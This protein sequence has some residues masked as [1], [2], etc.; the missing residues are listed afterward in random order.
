MSYK[1][2]LYKRTEITPI[3][4]A[5]QQGLIDSNLVCLRL[6]D[7]LDVDEVEHDNQ[8]FTRKIERP[9]LPPKKEYTVTKLNLSPD[10]M[11]ETLKSVEQAAQGATSAPVEEFHANFQ[12]F[13]PDNLSGAKIYVHGREMF[14]EKAAEKYFAP[15]TDKDA[16]AYNDFSDVA[17]DRIRHMLSHE[18]FGTRMFDYGWPTDRGEYV[19]KFM[20]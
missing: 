2:R 5:E 19:Q 14:S 15:E 3:R 20:E 16:F 7:N 12:V 8:S 10:E 11:A 4:K 9:K 6:S 18:T 17:K 1:D 13:A